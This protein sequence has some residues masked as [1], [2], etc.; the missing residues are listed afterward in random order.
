M[1]FA[2]SVIMGSDNCSVFLFS[3]HGHS[4]LKV[5]PNVRPSRY[6]WLAAICGRYAPN[7][8]GLFSGEKN[9]PTRLVLHTQVRRF[10][11]FRTG[12]HFQKTVYDRTIRTRRN[13]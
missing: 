2:E 10:M 12:I 1:H 8:F 13:F 6:L 9:Y 3:E 4:T 5:Q 11:G 7:G